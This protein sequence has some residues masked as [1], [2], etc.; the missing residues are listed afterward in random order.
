MP[1]PLIEHFALDPSVVYLNHGSFGACPRRVLERQTELRERLERGP[2]RFFM[3]DLP[4]LLE[5]ARAALA[6]FVGA[7]A[8]DVAF[9]RNATSGV[10]AVLSSLRFE[11]GDELLTT[12]HAYR[13]CHNALAHAA[14]RSGAT[15]VV[16]KV[17]F[18]I[19]SSA[20]AAEAILS[21]VSARTK[22]VMLDHVT[23]ATGLVLPVEALVHEL[24]SRGVAVLV[25]GAHAP[26]MLT[27][28]L[29]RLGASYY[30]GNLHKWVC[31]PK[32]AALL[33]VR[34]D[35][36]AG[37]HPSVVSHGFSSRRPRS[38]F[39]EEF[40]WCGT[41]DPTSWLCV[42]EALRA[43]AGLVPGGWPEVMR[44]N[45]ALALAAR[46]RLC[47][48][49]AIEAPA[50]ESMIGTLVTLPISTAG[51]EALSAFDIDPLQTALFE[52]H[53][54]EVPVFSWPAPPARWFRISAQ[55]YNAE[56]DYDALS[57]ALSELGAFS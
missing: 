18:P 36:Q 22:L 53:H 49:L 41:D 5:G 1:S 48:E 25:D 13:A 30:T 57:R 55:L 6:E 54:I 38:R 46:A 34:R 20:A 24:E 40:D 19:A 50:P 27:L 37:L 35:R 32:G 23:S 10:G 21:R 43:V 9:L 56:Q 8:E 45:H 17:P 3:R 28:N 7:A 44:R 16:A 31:A 2:V 12:N 51:P 52:Q 42:P 11:P 47:G 33:H 39:L 14:E 15:L 26:G 4:E 29:T